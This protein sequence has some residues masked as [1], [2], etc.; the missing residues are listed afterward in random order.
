M[1]RKNRL[2]QVHRNQCDTMKAHLHQLR[3]KILHEATIMTSVKCDRNE[4]KDKFHMFLKT[5]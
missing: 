1:E 3:E 4:Q 5:S 2:P